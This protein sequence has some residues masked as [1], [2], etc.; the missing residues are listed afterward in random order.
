MALDVLKFD[1][2]CYNLLRHGIKGVH[3]SMTEDGYWKPEAASDSWPFGNA[4]S[5]GFK[6]SMYET[7]RQ[8]TFADQVK[9]G[10]DWTARAVDSPTAA[11]SFD[12]SK[13]KNELASLQSV[14]TQYVPLLDLGLV[15]D[16]ASTL[17][18]FQKQAEAAGLD[19][20]LEEA[21]A[22]LD[23]FFREQ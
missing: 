7:T 5:W 10:D 3:Y 9:I 11:F 4:V 21:K 8:D 14:Y 13:V 20:I 12:D 17:A 15:S 22:Q 16:V 23:V 18:E 6:N 2:T 1:K 19:R